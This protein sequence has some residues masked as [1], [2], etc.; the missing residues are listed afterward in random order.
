MLGGTEENV[1]PSKGHWFALR[2]DQCFS[3]LAPKYLIACGLPGI[4]FIVLLLSS[5]WMILIWGKWTG[6]SLVLL[7]RW[8]HTRPICC[9]GFILRD[10]FVCTLVCQVISMKWSHWEHPCHIYKFFFSKN[11]TKNLENSAIG[12]RPC[13]VSAVTTYHQQRSFVFMAYSCQF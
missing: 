13:A 8:N 5:L 12:T 10:K 11:E 4:M 3:Y 7:N 1:S 6:A 9:P 2:A